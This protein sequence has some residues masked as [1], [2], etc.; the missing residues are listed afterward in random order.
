MNDCGEEKLY[1]SVARIEVQLNE[2]VS[3]IDRMSRE[4]EGRIQDHEL[5]LRKIEDSQSQLLGK[6]T[7]VWIITTGAVAA[8]VSW[9]TTW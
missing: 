8:L 1:A 4:N 2:L 3:R 6:L 5:R 7:A 9:M